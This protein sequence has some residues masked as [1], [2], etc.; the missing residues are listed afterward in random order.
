ML[1][2][3]TGIIKPVSAEKAKEYVKAYSDLGLNTSTFTSD[4]KKLV[5]VLATGEAGALALASDF[6]PAAPKEAKEVK[7][8]G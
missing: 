1:L 7:N 6:V 2:T 4:D 8:A 3:D 5:L